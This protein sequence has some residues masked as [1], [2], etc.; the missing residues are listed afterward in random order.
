MLT[1][2][3]LSITDELIKIEDI[4]EIT[5]SKLFINAAEPDPEGLASYEI[6]DYPGTEGRKRK[7][8]F[9]SLNDWF[10]HPHCIFELKSLKSIYMDLINGN[11]EFYIKDGDLFKV[12]GVA[13]EGV[14]T[15]SGVGFLYSIWELLTFDYK[16][17]NYG[18]RYNRLRFI[19]SLDKSQ[20][21]INKILVVPPFYRDIDMRDGGSKNEYN[22]IYIKIMNLTQIMKTTKT[23]FGS[24]NSGGVSESYRS[25]T[26]ILI[27]FHEM[28]IKMFGGRKGFIHKNIMGKSVDYS[29]RLVISCLDLTK[30]NSPSEMTVSFKKSVIPLFAAIKC[31]APFIVNGIKDIITDYLKGSDYLILVHDIKYKSNFALPDR[32]F[33]KF[34]SDSNV[35]ITRVKLASDWRVALT[36]TYIYNL[37]EL[38]HES[39]EHRLDKFTLPTE[40]GTEVGINF[41]V[42]DG[43]DMELESDIKTA[44]SKMY[45]LR[46]V[47]LFYMA[48]IDKLVNKHVLITRYP[49]E[50][51]NNTYPTGINIIPYKR[52]SKLKIGDTV[53]DNFPIVDY[54]N[55]IKN[56]SSMFTDSLTIFPGYLSAM[57]ADFDGDMV[58]V[59]GL[60]TNEANADAAKY[61]TSNANLCSIDGTSTKPLGTLAAQTIYCLTFLNGE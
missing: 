12:D 18:M 31:F 2:D 3:I 45:P 9:I 5:S 25:I 61:I 20:V 26:N 59:I 58:S 21:F 19:K 8:G 10:V 15:G 41:Y 24:L 43:A 6:F 38:Y 51:H 28:I 16:D 44:N 56:I 14:K 42:N 39:P 4:K 29:S 30:T 32:L 36:T 37:I 7:F 27:D 54:E 22:N 57:D 55:D 47:H 13:P 49:I 11:G 17:L 35:E 46:L 52:V 1:Y 50:D 34:K 60:F 23:M 40:D 33:S 48:A 53:Y